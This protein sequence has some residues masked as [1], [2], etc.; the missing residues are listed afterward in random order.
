MILPTYPWFAPIFKVA[1]RGKV[2]ST[3][4]I[5]LKSNEP[6]GPESASFSHRSIPP[7]VLP[8]PMKE[9]PCEIIGPKP[10][11]RP[12]CLLVDPGDICPPQA[13]WERT[14]AGTAR[15][16]ASACK[17]QKICMRE[18]NPWQPNS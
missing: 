11:T 13:P 15:A 9:W 8:W 5:A 2:G 7:A 18:K 12:S 1:A 4:W 16:W 3:L 14:G 6:L 17:C 10:F